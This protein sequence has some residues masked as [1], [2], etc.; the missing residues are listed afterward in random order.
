MKKTSVL[1]GAITGLGM[2]ASGQL[3]AQGYYVD[4]QSALRLGD[5]F[6]GGSASA[7]D[8]STVFYGPAAMVKLDDE[9]VVNVAAVN[10]SSSFDGAATTAGDMPIN[11]KDAESDSLDFLPSVYFVRE[12]SDGFKMGLYMNAPYATGTDFG[13]NSVARYQASVSEITGI[14]A[15]FALAMRLND[16]VSIGGSFI[17]QYVNAKTAVAINTVALCLGTVDAELGAGTCDALGVDSSTLGDTDYDG[18]FEMEGHNMAYG[19][20][21]GTLIEFSPESR[22]GINYRSRIAHKLSGDAEVT[23]PDNAAGFTG[24]ADLPN[25]KADGKVSLTTPETASISYFHSLGSVALQ[26][27][28]SWTKWSRYDEVKVRSNDSVVTMLAEAPQVYN[29]TESQRIAIG[30]SWQVTPELTLRTGMAVDKTP[31]EDKYAKVDFAFD[32]YQAISVGMSYVLSEDLT[33]DVGL[34]HTFEQ[35][36][37]IEQ[38]DLATSASKLTGEVTTEVNSYA[39]GI[40][41]KL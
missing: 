5:A 18:Y 36:R 34:Q 31:I 13:K 19:F 11:G 3:L 23:F 20:A 35:T 25:T 4:E 10:F 6:S 24:I 2:L 9:L 7:S 28:Y 8:A 22:L 26:A 21:L 30:A 17:A 37:D 27:D 29:W 38:D 12:L 1:T 33:L 40:R 41:W 32:D 14:D 15:G 39:A 16:M